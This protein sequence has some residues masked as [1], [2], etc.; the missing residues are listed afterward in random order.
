MGE[1]SQEIVQIPRTR[2]LPVPHGAPLVTQPKD[3]A[4][5]R[6]AISKTVVPGRP[7]AVLLAVAAATSG[8]TS[9]HPAV[10]SHTLPSSSPTVSPTAPVAAP[11]TPR[12]TPTHLAAAHLSTPPPPRKDPSPTTSRAPAAPPPPTFGGPYTQP[13]V[14]STSVTHACRKIGT[15]TYSASFQVVATGGKNWRFQGEDSANGTTGYFTE[16]ISTAG[17]DGNPPDPHPTIVFASFQVNSQSGNQVTIHEI[18]IPQSLR[19]SSTC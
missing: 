14:K 9:G 18:E 4:A 17:V 8:C 15:N 1:R 5:M 3:P 7:L 6:I 19:S 12:L 2:L 10:S 16:R 13:A 11:L